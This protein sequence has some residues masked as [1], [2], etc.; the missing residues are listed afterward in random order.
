MTMDDLVDDPTD[1]PDKDWETID[2]LLRC[3]SCKD[4]LN[5]ARTVTSCGH[6]FCS[7]CLRQ[8]L[9]S[10]QMAGAKH[11][12][13]C[14]CKIKDYNNDTISNGLIDSILLPYTA[15]RYVYGN[16]PC[17]RITTVS[18]IEKKLLLL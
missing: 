17:I 14:N 12:P 16:A 1:W 7:L 8:A 13:I 6:T 2:T 18:S 15:V 10:Q 3:P 4:L 5:I 9:D 11:C